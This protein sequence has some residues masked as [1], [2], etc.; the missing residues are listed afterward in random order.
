MALCA[1]PVAALLEVEAVEALH[2]LL[3]VS[4]L[5]HAVEPVEAAEPIVPQVVSVLVDS[6]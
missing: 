1:Q 3:P 4:A 5:L 6:T 2:L